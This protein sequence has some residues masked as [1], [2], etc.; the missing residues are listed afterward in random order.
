MDF[1]IYGNSRHYVT[2]YTWNKNIPGP[3]LHGRALK[4]VVIVLNNM[5]IT[6]GTLKLTNWLFHVVQNQPRIIHC[7]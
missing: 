5:L 4:I 6:I 1:I 3:A 7:Y 2:L